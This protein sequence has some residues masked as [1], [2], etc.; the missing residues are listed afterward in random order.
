M[1]V[2]W[3]SEC[4]ICIGK[5]VAMNWHSTKPKKWCLGEAL[6]NPD[7]QLVQQQELEKRNEKKKWAD[8][9]HAGSRFGVT[10]WKA[11]N[12]DDNKMQTKTNTA[13]S[14]SSH[15]CFVLNSFSSGDITCE[16]IHPRFENIQQMCLHSSLCLHKGLLLVT[17]FQSSEENNVF[18]QFGCMTFLQILCC[19]VFRIAF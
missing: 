9:I 11:A 14:I 3:S 13:I 19:N 12:D 18:L 16:V 2:S 15:W 8:A 5:I 7:H 10:L 4:S 6:M 17:D 1:N